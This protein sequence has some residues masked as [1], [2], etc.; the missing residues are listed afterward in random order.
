MPKRA[1]PLESTICILS[2]QQYFRSKEQ[3]AKLRM[4]KLEGAQESI[5]KGVW[6][7]V[8][9]CHPLKPSTALV[10]PATTMLASPVLGCK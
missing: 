6:V 4:G 1:V 9:V 3:I 10:L 2:R 5:S 8:L 7:L